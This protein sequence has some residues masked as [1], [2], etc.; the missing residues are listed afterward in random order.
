MELN[1][2]VF[3]ATDRMRCHFSGLAAVIYEIMLIVVHK[4]AGGH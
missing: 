1:E 3:V 4:I 2:M